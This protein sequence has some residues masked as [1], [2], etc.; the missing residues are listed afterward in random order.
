MPEDVL[1]VEIALKA[2]TCLTIYF[3]QELNQN[4]K[5]WMCDL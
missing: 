5:I 1:A 3:P 2:F 4:V